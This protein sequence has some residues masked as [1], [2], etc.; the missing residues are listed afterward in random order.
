MI[1]SRTKFVILKIRGGPTLAFAS[2]L[3]P[4]E[5]VLVLRIVTCHQP[6]GAACSRRSLTTATIPGT[7][8]PA[9]NRQKSA[10]D[11]SKSSLRQLRTFKTHV[12]IFG[13]E[14]AVYLRLALAGSKP[15]RVPNAQFG[16]KD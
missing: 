1:M 7:L 16:F 13:S 15:S 5:I 8:P 10:G 2:K 6:C 14:I 9:R 12:R 4:T 3:A 11:G